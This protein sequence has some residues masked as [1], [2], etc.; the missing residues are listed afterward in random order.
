MER[1]LNVDAMSFHTIYWKHRDD[2]DRGSLSGIA[3]WEHVAK[4]L[5]R[6]LTA[7]QLDALVDAD[8]ALW[9]QPNLPMIL[10][11]EALHSAGI[12]TGILSNLGDAMEAGI[13]ARCPWLGAFTHHTFSYR[14]GVAKPDPSIYLHAAQGLRTAPKHILFI[15]DRA[16]NIAAAAA[17]GMATIH[18][19]NHT[20][21]L[22]SLK[23]TR[24]G[25]LPEP[26]A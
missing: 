9:T 1:I 22:Q 13:L 11:A 6:D 2:Y 3:Y 18:Y 14:L 8:T 12:K 23:H 20:H 4:D 10:W 26:T 5:G 24:Y 19:T 7:I 25:N 15:D 17:V 21:F 16:E